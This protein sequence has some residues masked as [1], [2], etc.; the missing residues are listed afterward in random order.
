MKVFSFVVSSVLILILL[1]GVCFGQS[2]TEQLLTPEQIIFTESLISDVR[3]SPDGQRILMAV[4]EPKQYPSPATSHIWELQTGSRQLRQ[5][6][7]TPKAEVY[8]RWAPDGSRLAYIST[9]EGT[10]Q[11]YLLPAGGGEAVRLTD[12]KRPSGRFAWSP[13][14]KQIAFFSVEPAPTQAGADKRKEDDPIVLVTGREEKPNQRLRRLWLID[15]ATKE[16]RQLVTGEW[17]FSE[18]DWM[19]DGTG[20]IVTAKDHPESSKAKWRIYSVSLAAN[21]MKLLAEPIGDPFQI[22]VSPDGKRLGFVARQTP[23]ANHKDLFIQSFAGGPT[24]NLTATSI[25]R[26][27]TSFL[28]LNDRTIMTSSETGFGSSLHR[29]RTDGKAEKVAAIN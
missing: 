6:T 7:N 28:W 9:V 2:K 18:I 1:P 13:D 22:K 24:Q 8:P 3:F 25:D 21:S 12:G 5:L 15:I 10:A 19:P 23:G 27:V 20:L 11:I 14:G 17:D 26:N 29:V 16:A 4:A